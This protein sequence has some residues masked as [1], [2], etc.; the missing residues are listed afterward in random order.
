MTKA[1]AMTAAIG[2]TRQIY[3]FLTEV[4]DLTEEL[5][6]ALQQR[7][8]VTLRLFLKL[9]AEPLA[10]A[11]EQKRQLR[12]VCAS[13]P[14]GEGERLI[15][16]LSESVTDPTPEEAPLLQQ[17]RRNQ[18]LLKRIMETDRRVSLQ[19]GRDKSFY[20]PTRR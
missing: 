11:W 7:D 5:E 17:V 10:H 20:R 15:Q 14:D 3:R 19:M 9:R 16:I 2:H 8:M 4:S 13:L 6:R 18:A 1:D 12:K